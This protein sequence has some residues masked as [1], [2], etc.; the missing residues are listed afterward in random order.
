MN[1]NPERNAGTFRERCVEGIVADEDHCRKMLMDS[2]VIATALCPEFG[3]ERATAI[4]KRAMKEHKTVV[5]VAEEDL[6]IPR[7]AL[8]KIV[9][10]CLEDRR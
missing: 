8:E 6:S 9:S 1:Q 7:A 10:N 2:T 5:D 4:V 3:Y